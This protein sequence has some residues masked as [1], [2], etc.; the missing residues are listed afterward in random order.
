[1]ELWPPQ[2]VL[3]DKLGDPKI[4]ARLIGDDMGIGKTIESLAIDQR[5]RRHN[6]G[7]RKTLIIAPRS[8]HEDPWELTIRDYLGKRVFIIDRKNRAAF[9]KAVQG[10]EYEYFICH[11]EA[12]R[13]MKELAQVQFFH[14]IVDETH[15][16]KSPKAQVTLAIKRLTTVFKT[17]VSGTPADDKP[18]DL[19]S[20]L[21]FLYPGR[22]PS[23][24]R[25]V[26]TFCN[27]ETEEI[28]TRNGLQKIRKINGANKATAPLLL[29]NISGFYMRRL[30]SEVMKD[31]PPKYY[32]RIMIDLGPRQRKI[33]D[34]LRDQMLAWIGEHENEPLSTPVVVAQLVRLQQAALACLEWGDNGKVQLIEPSTKLDELVSKVQNEGLH[35]FV[36]FSQSKSMIKLT[37]R[38]LTK[39]GLHV[40]TL[41]GD[42]PE[43]DRGDWRKF[44]DGQFDVFAATIKS[45]GE[46]I[47]L[48]RA[49]TVFFED[50]S[51][52]PSA[53]MQAEDRLHR[54]TQE[55]AVQVID[56]MA[57]DSVDRRVRETN[58]KKWSDLRTILGDTRR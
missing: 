31:L 43:R 47:T 2:Q 46:S 42:T 17:S 35:P 22:F 24:W 15:R 19:W 58:I 38:R 14:V 57:R 26:N 12:M 54:A 23:Y 32:S 33:Y 55:N 5:L 45:G 39:E 40:A 10:D 21:N 44:Q 20:T 28:R 4:R 1:M 29:D 36:V 49:S 8:S 41:T 53:N 27:V 6:A 30:K 56:L 3:V 9:I 18:Q 50:R 52:S 37:A 16:I 48:T 34:D 7:Y 51:W 13:L 11:H 25:F